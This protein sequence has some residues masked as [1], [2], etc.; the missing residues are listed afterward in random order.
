MGEVC[1]EEL[2]TPG[3]AWDLIVA[4]YKTGL[5]LKDMGRKGEAEAHL[6]LAFEKCKILAERHPRYGKYLR[7]LEN[8]CAGER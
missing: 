5:C 7:T 8:A 3:A 4:H 2:G 1:G 6:R